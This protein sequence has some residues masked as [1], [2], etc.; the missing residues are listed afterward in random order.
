[1]CR[2]LSLLYCVA[3]G[4]F[5][6]LSLVFALLK[7]IGTLLLFKKQEAFQET[8]LRTLGVLAKEGFRRLYF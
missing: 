7:R 3:A 8:N 1:M 4:A 5:G 6:S 2:D